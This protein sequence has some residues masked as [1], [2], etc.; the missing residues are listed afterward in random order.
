[1]LPQERLEVYA[2][3]GNSIQRMV[4]VCGRASTRASSLSS[5]TVPACRL[6]CR[7]SRLRMKSGTTL[8]HRYERGV[9]L[10][11]TQLSVP[12]RNYCQL[13]SCCTD[14]TCGYVCCTIEAL[15]LC[16]QHDSGDSCTP[17][18]SRGSSAGNY[19]MFASATSGERSNNRK[20]SSCSKGN[21][22]A[23]STAL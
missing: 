22:S 16:L 2:S 7:R 18:T 6:K 19:I 21:I 8:A 3:G 23:V 5:T 4:T 1:M 10:T 17:Y 13:Y 15:W 14:V 11:S 12:C 9:L 20:F